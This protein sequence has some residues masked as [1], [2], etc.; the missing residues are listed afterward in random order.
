M[1]LERRT[2]NVFL[3]PKIQLFLN[4]IKLGN[5]GK[6]YLKKLI[7]LALLGIAGSVSAQTFLHTDGMN[8]VDESGKKVL[9]RGVG[10]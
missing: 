8:I 2:V 9:L 3:S 7:F 5:M 1:F 6:T 10:S 4:N